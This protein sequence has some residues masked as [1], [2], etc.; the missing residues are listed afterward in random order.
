[1]DRLPVDDRSLARTFIARHT[2]ATEAN[3]QAWLGA[4]AAC[5]RTP[6]AKQVTRRQLREE[7]MAN[8]ASLLRS[9]A[10]A[11]G[12]EP[13]ARHYRDV[14]RP[15]DA[16]RTVIAKM[17]GVRS[18]IIMTL[19]EGIYAASVMPCLAS[20]ARDLKSPDLRYTDVHCEADDL[21]MRD[22]VR[23]LIA[24]RRNSGTSDVAMTVTMRSALSCIGEI[25]GL[26]TT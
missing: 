21:H 9:F 23:A 2:A 10:V 11:A 4:T 26:K 19:L 25:Y 14:F 3:F 6:L 17:N 20:F 22:L 1:L 16:L 7:M 8:H 5:V 18:L 12:A 15:I 24:E 13:S